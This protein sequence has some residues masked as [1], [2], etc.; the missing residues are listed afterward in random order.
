MEAVVVSCIRQA[1]DTPLAD[2]SPGQPLLPRW[3]QE[4]VRGRGRT[5]MP[6]MMVKLEL[7][8]MREVAAPVHDKTVM[9]TVSSDGNSG[10]PGIQDA[11]TQTRMRK[12]RRPTLRQSSLRAP[13]GTTSGPFADRLGHAKL[14]KT[15]RVN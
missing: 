7:E 10:A 14:S 5:P 11:E 2:A 8:P 15:S 13:V 6:N 4:C 9:Q 3:H 1:P 12:I